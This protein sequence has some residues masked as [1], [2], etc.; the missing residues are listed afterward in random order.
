[1]ISVKGLKGE[2]K[3]FNEAA[4]EFEKSVREYVTR[5]TADPSGSIERTNHPVCEGADDDACIAKVILAA[6]CFTML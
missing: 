5:L 1:M 4:R 6:V 3:D 2:F